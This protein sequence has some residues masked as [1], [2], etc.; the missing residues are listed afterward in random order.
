MYSP[1]PDTSLPTK[2]WYLADV[3]NKEG[4]DQLP[5]YCPYDCPIG[6]V[7]G[8]QISFGCIIH[9]PSQSS[10]CILHRTSI[11][12]LIRPS[13]SPAET[14]IFFMFKKDSSL[15]PSV[16]YKALSRITVCNHFLL[17]LMN[18]LFERF[19]QTMIFSKLDL[20]G[21]YNLV[22]TW[23][24]EEW[25]TTFSPPMGI[26]NTWLCPLGSAMP[27]INSNILKK[28]YFDICWTNLL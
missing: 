8:A 25:K 1:N 10:R 12:V 21:A 22:H 14:P 15:R 13:I 27:L 11:K 19:C 9:S 20:Q 5:P 28:M 26:L 16:N 24:R 23:E 2:Y 18:E 4:V 6:L 7:P 3:F 17:L